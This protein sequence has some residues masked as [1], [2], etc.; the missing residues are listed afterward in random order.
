MKIVQERLSE[1]KLKLVA[2]YQ[3]KEI[4]EKKLTKGLSENYSV[5]SI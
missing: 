2:A 1:L 5:P 4:P 3:D